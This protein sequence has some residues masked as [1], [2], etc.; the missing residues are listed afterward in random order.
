MGKDKRFLKIKNENLLDRQVSILRKHF[1]RILISANDPEKIAYLNLP[2]IKDQNIGDGPLEGL[3]SAL[4]ASRTDYNFVIAVDIPQ[5]DMDLVYKLREHIN[6]VSAVI[7][8]CVDGRQEPLFAFYNRACVPIFREALK[9]R[10][11]AIYR[12]LQKCP[13]Y[14][15]PMQ[16]ETPLRNLNREEDYEKYVSQLE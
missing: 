3:T 15:F 10:E 4:A 8:V 9:N 14:H 1:D 11:L 13:V 6:N 16:E 12:A 5:I 7:P 2:V